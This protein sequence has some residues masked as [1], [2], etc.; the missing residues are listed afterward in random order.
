LR[1]L[2]D[3]VRGTLRQRKAVKTNTPHK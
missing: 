2:V 1:A 3:E